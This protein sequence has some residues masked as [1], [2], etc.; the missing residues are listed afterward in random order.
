VKTAVTFSRCNA[1]SLCLLLLICSTTVRDVAAQQKDTI[2]LQQQKIFHSLHDAFADPSSV[3]RLDLSRQHL[4]ELPDSL[5]LLVQLEELILAG[6]QL[7]QLSPMIGRL[8]NLRILEL[9]NNRLHGLPPEIGKLTQLT[10]LFLNRNRIEALPPEISNLTQLA[11]LSLWGNRIITLPIEMMALRATLQ[12]ID[13]RG[14]NIKPEYRNR[15][16]EMLPETN[17]YFSGCNCN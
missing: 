13:M 15:I 14:I 1:L 9:S 8:K 7:D 12:T 10:H 4:K 2:V 11:E 17:I 16:T 6:N 5:F 3:Y